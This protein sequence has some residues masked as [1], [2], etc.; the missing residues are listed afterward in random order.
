M[1]KTYYELTKMAGY[2]IVCLRNDQHS[3]EIKDGGR[4]V[5]FYK[6]TKNQDFLNKTAEYK[7]FFDD[8]MFKEGQYKCVTEI[9]AK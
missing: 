4:L 9:F 5:F 2:E 7:M 6:I 1:T 8:F 3:A